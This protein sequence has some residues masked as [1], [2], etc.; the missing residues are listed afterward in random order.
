MVLNPKLR[1]LAPAQENRQPNG[2]R[3]PVGSRQHDVKSDDHGSGS[4]SESE[5]KFGV[6]EPAPEGGRQNDWKDGAAA[7]RVAGRGAPGPIV[8][9]YQRFPNVP[10]PAF[11]ENPLSLEDDLAA[12]SWHLIIRRSQAA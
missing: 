9:R 5:S 12:T 6:D 7:G 1:L 11:A 4:G 8:I 10:F 3:P 2:E